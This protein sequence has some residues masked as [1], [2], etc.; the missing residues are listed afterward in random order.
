MADRKNGATAAF[1]IYDS[2]RPDSGYAAAKPHS[3]NTRD[4]S[5]ISLG[6]QYKF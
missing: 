6:A 2:W 5:G 3:A 1:T 4:Q